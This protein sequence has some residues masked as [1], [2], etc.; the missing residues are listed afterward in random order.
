ML[1]TEKLNINEKQENI[2]KNNTSISEKHDLH[3]STDLTDIHSYQERCKE[4][5]L[6]LME[7]RSALDDF[8][9]T[10]KEL[11]D[12][13]EQ[14]L[15]HTEKQYQILKKKNTL[16]QMEI[17][18]WK[19]K[20]EQYR[21]QSTESM[22]AMQQE[23]ETLRESHKHIKSKVVDLE[24][25]NDAMENKERIIQSSFDD[26]GTKYN[27][28]LEKNALLEA[29]LDA[30]KSLDIDNQRLKDELRDTYLELSLTKEKLQKV[31]IEK[32][33]MASRALLWRHARH[34]SNPSI[35]QTTSTTNT[36]LNEDKSEANSNHTNIIFKTPTK[37]INGHAQPYPV[38]TTQEI[39]KQVK[40]TESTSYSR[41]ILKKPFEPQPA[42]EHSPIRPT[43]ASVLNND[44][45]KTPETPKTSHHRHVSSPSSIQDTQNIQLLSQK[46]TSLLPARSL[47]NNS[48]PIP[49]PK[50]M[51]PTDTVTRKKQNIQSLKTNTLETVKES[52]NKSFR[53]FS[54]KK[55]V[56]EGAPIKS[57]KRQALYSAIPVPKET[58][59]R[60]VSGIPQ[61]LHP[62]K[63]TQNL[64]RKKSLHT[65]SSNH[66]P[67]TTHFSTLANPYKP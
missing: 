59:K 6:A 9:I 34:S 56:L 43:A 37:K 63:L 48:P 50:T 45:E 11:E 28:I 4:L 25:S 55:M 54:I 17:E 12:A 62:A 46:P 67:N 26:L 64:L 23:V 27:K 40:N 60:R 13:L 22:L 18:Q 39:P 38:R 8:Q 51:I 20:Y 24:L 42:Q 30:Q 1:S 36:T 14:E 15:E 61:G 66:P 52:I 58:P 32:E 47:P 3:N 57:P 7:A 16:L 49:L 35:A 19:N 10:S 41:S 2:K 21:K 31:E 44:H 53:R 29:E 65:M 33:K 5:E